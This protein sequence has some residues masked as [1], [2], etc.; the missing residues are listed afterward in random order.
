MRSNFVV[1]KRQKNMKTNNYQGALQKSINS[2]FNAKSTTGDVIKGIDLKGKNAIVTGG[3]VGIGLETTI[4]LATAGANVIVLARDVEK[5]KINLA[6]IAN[7]E[8]EKFDLANPASVDEFAKKF[9]ATGQAL[10][11]LI[12][13]AGIMW[14]PLRKDSRG[15]ESQ[16]ATNHLGHFQLTARLWSA[17]KKA[18]GARVI[19]LSS[20]GHHFSSFNFEDP[21]FE[22]RE[23]QTLQGYGQSKTATNLFSLELDNLGKEF[24]VRS[25]SVHPGSVAGTELGREAD[26]ELW[27]KMGILDESGNIRPEVLETLK[28]IPQGA[29]TTVWC[30]T[31]PML[32]ELGGVY[33]EDVNIAE[34]DNE[35]L[36][37]EY[38]GVS[39]E[40]L[41][42]NSAKKLW[43]LSETMTGVEFQLI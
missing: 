18:N 8:I 39:P 28:T 25:Y 4:T 16:L 11:L 5:A 43:K 12:N 42:E 10:H 34:L 20:Y 3:N 1:T 32:D 37:A 33:C 38:S 31:S 7:V 19:N 21:N 2:G 35:K 14:V 9:I 36:S 15:I 17:L 13:N 41:D 6:G 24:N 40:S 22:F 29:A 30:A 27:K 23:Y 26:A